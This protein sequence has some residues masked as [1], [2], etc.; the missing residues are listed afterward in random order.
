LIIIKIENVRICGIL[1]YALCKHAINYYCVFFLVIK[2]I[3]FFRNLNL[4][5]RKEHHPIA[6]GAK[7]QKRK[8]FA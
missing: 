5:R 3:K 7:Y 1:D 6:E 4:C 2:F 8:L